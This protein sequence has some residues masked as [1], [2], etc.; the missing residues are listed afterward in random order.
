MLLAIQGGSPIMRQIIT[1]CVL[2]AVTLL[3]AACGGGAAGSV[4]PQ[5]MPGLWN[6]LAVHAGGNVLK[7]PCFST[8]KLSPWTAVGKPP[9]EGA[10]S[11]KEVYTCKYS[12]LMGTL[13]PPAVDKLHGIEQK[14]EIPT[15]GEL[16][17]WYYAGTND[18]PK[19][20]DQEVDLM[21]GT[22]LVYQCFKKLSDTKKWTK[23]T[24]DLSKYAGKTYDLVLGVNDNGYDKTYVYWY[25]DD[26]SLATK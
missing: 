5:A 6:A 23:G 4:N 16:T 26:L 22:T 7:N 12:A 24:C 2:T 17:W 18:S 1:G 14:V 9:G 13:T 25:V 15:N 10:I 20:A 21:S 19:Y 8:G 3:C 11:T